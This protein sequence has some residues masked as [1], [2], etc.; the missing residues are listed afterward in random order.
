MIENKQREAA[1]LGAGALVFVVG[2]A[3]WVFPREAASAFGTSALPG[4]RSRW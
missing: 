4:P 1:L 3:T 2:C